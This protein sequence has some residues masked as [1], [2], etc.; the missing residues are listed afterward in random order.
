MKL[1]QKS[2]EDNRSFDNSESGLTFNIKE[3]MDLK[4]QKRQAMINESNT[5]KV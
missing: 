3:M 2:E 4:K 5:M 1:I